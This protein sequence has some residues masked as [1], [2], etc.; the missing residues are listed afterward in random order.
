MWSSAATAVVMLWT[1][2][3][4]LLAQRAAMPWMLAAMPPGIPV[5]IPLRRA[6]HLTL[7]QPRSHAHV[8]EQTT[9]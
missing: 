2:F 3:Q 6:H 1:A 4:R 9:Q 7:G 5:M 8:L